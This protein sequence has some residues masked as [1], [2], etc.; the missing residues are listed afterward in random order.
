MPQAMKWTL[1]KKILVGY[2][3]V[4]ALLLFVFS[5]AFL[6]LTW[7]GGASDAMLTENYD[8]IRAADKM[9]GAVERQESG[10]LLHWN[11]FEAEGIAQFQENQSVFL[12]W[13]ARAEDNITIDGER[14][15]IDRISG[16]Y[17]AYTAGFTSVLRDGLT[18]EQAYH[19]RMQPTFQ[20]VRQACQDLRQVNLE[21]M[22]AQS[23]QT[24]A[25][26]DRA[27]WSVGG[28][29]L[30]AISLGLLFSALLSKRIVRPIKQLQEA[31]QALAAGDYDARVDVQSQDELGALAEQFN[32]MADRLGAY[33]ALNVERVIAEKRKNETIIQ[34]MA[35][36][37]LI[38]HADG[39]I[40]TANPVAEDVLGEPL[41]R[42]QGRPLSEALQ[43]EPLRKTVQRALDPPQSCPQPKPAQPP[44]DRQIERSRN[45]TTR[46]FDY[47]VTPLHTGH[48]DEHGGAVV[49]FRDVTHF[50]EVDRLK[51]EF[52]AT[53]SHQL[54]TPLTSIAMSIRLLMESS[55]STFSP[56]DYELLEAAEED[57]VRLR[58][59][60]QDLLDLSKVESGSMEMDR[61]SLPLQLLFEKT[62]QVLGGQAEA[63]G[64]ALDVDAPPDHATVFAD[65]TKVTWV[66]TNLVS[67]ALRYTSGGGT[68][69]LGADVIGDKIHISVRDDGVGIPYEHQ[70]KIFDKFVQLTGTGE[71][72]G[73]GL[74]L[75]ISR[76]VVRAHG[77]TLWVDSAP[78]EGSCFTFTLPLS[79][80]RTS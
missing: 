11:A 15:I 71:T 51:S 2:G 62:H 6:S 61:Q 53:A 75:A 48:A 23:E 68:I 38:V 54:K 12:Q 30:L 70:A 46:H 49:L 5:W 57:T 45:G 26:A 63:K 28:V 10:L 34:N 73:S 4:L 21:T 43:H 1:R 3:L 67:N 40:D 17:A 50:K 8:S 72:G 47:E 44:S 39:T 55:E 35:D 7:L 32:T 76:E 41:A 9:I 65:A 66:L 80:A 16:A 77:G 24:Q 69:A 20:E 78:G 79:S 60:T 33:Q 37:V 58:K 56:D 36:G 14:E 19:E 59:L 18:A 64:I 25:L 74:G 13:L 29:G 27:I 42:M 31:S 52:V 22:Q